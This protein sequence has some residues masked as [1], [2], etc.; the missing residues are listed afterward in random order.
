MPHTRDW[1]VED[2]NLDG[3]T[4]EDLHSLIAF[5]GNGVRPVNAARKWFPNNRHGQI[6]AVQDIRNY[7]WNKITA[8]SCRAEGKIQSALFYEAICDRIYKQMPKFAR[9]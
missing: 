6:L 4:V 9:W 8:M 1:K 5:I 2:L 3:M 7:A